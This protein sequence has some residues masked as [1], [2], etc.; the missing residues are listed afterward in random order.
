M[1]MIYLFKQCNLYP[2]LFLYINC[3][4]K[5]ELNKVVGKSAGAAHLV[6]SLHRDETARG[7][8]GRGPVLNSSPGVLD[9]N[10][11]NGGDA[12]V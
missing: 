12:F 7:E 2:C 8:A 1:M 10:K 11:I 3:I 6:G 4:I 5:E 9:R